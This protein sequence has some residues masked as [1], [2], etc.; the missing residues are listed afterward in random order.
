MNRRYQSDTIIW[1]S[2][3]TIPLF[4]KWSVQ[5][6]FQKGLLG[7]W[8]ISDPTADPIVPLLNKMYKLE[9]DKKRFVRAPDIKYM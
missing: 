5:V 6:K 7:K 3:L 1:F 2:C 4:N 9:I 8:N